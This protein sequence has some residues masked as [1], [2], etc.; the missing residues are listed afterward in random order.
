MNTKCVYEVVDEHCNRSRFAFGKGLHTLG[1]NITLVIRLFAHIP[2]DVRHTEARQAV[3]QW[4]AKGGF[5]MHQRWLDRV[6]ITCAYQLR[7]AID[8]A[9]HEQMQLTH[10]RKI[11][12]K[13]LP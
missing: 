2:N 3:H 10:D 9:G 4:H 8:R 13:C 7:V 5:L 12:F 6:Q 1:F 11:V